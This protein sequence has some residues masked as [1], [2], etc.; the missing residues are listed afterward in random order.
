MKTVV[1][2]FVCGVTCHEG[3]KN[4]NGY[5]IDGRIPH[6]DTYTELVKEE[7]DLW[8]EVLEIFSEHDGRTDIWEK[9]MSKYSIKELT[10]KQ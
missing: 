3:D 1:K 2:S 5:C 6:P 4:C 8:M 7:K 9:L 10:T